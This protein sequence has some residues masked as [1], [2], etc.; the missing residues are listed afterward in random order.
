MFALALLVTSLYAS[1]FTS[2]DANGNCPKQNGKVGDFTMNVLATMWVVTSCLNDKPGS[3]VGPVR[4]T[5]L[6]TI[7]GLWP[8]KNSTTWPE[9]CNTSYPFKSSEISGLSN[10]KQNWISTKGSDD[11]FYAHEWEKHGTCAMNL[12]S[13]ERAYFEKTVGLNQRLNLGGILSRA[14]INP[15]NT[16]YAKSSVLSA[17]KN[18]LG[19]E[20]LLECATVN[21]QKMLSAVY[22]CTDA[23]SSLRVQSCTSDYYSKYAN[24]CPANFYLPAIPD[25]CYR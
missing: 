2:L 9:C 7:H 12:F 11:S 24:K 14:G 5:S 20:P 13:S 18:G 23:S 8:G 10:L 15:G 21:G 6:F 3:G 4:G 1:Q 22:V 17:L 25:S 16:M 19:A